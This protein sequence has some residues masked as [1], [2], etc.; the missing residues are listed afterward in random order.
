MNRSSL[1]RLPRLRPPSVR[2][3]GRSG[4]DPEEPGGREWQPG[5]AIPS[6]SELA[7]RFNVSQG[8]VRK[9]IDE[10]AALRTCW[11]AGRAKYLRRHAQRPRSFFRFLRLVP[12]EA[13]LQPSRSVPLECGVPGRV[14][15]WRA[16]S[17]W[18]PGH[19]HHHAPPAQV[20]R[21]CRCLRRDLP[22]G[23]TLGIRWTSSSRATSRST[24]CS[25]VATAFA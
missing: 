10:M 24:T 23:R 3:I 9:A 6:E 21:G 17:G 15:T 11:S 7:V 16:C 12:N 2:S 5:D 25:R 14:P 20:R 13:S 4:S 18:S 1:S 8:T 19:R 22:A